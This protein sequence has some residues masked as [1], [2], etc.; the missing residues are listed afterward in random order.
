MINAK[1]KASPSCKIISETAVRANNFASISLKGIETL[2]EGTPPKNNYRY[3][4]K[5]RLNITQEGKNHT[6]SQNKKEQ[7]LL[8]K[9]F[10]NK[11][12]QDTR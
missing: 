2:E 10:S 7:N 12:T 11:S 4:G 6:S 9:Q 3:I 5:K 8:I 1:S